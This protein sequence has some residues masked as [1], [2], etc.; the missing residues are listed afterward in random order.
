MEEDHQRQPLLEHLQELRKRIIWSVIVI[1]VGLIGSF[2]SVTP[3]FQYLVSVAPVENL[4]LNAL[5][6]FDAI[7]LYMKFALVISLV[8]AL[9]FMLFQIWAFLKPALTPLE[10]RETLRCVP[11]VLI[12]FL[13][14]V[15][16]AYY[17][18]FPMAFL[19]T[20]RVTTSMGLKETYGV[21]QYFTFLFNIV[22]PVSLLFELPLVI[23][24]L[25]KLGILNPSMLTKMRKVAWFAMIVI[26]TLVTP[27]DFI[28][29]ILV[30]VPLIVLYEF[31]VMLSRLT[32]RK[33]L[34]AYELRM[35]MQ[36]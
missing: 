29:D 15:A 6:P 18:V 4:E 14:G 1:A 34:A 24:F 27:P 9:P 7:G 33:N 12:M 20:E 13:L 3:L 21:I 30:S 11:G 5:S 22:M 31:S 16:F 8:L 35:T 25:T 10:Q 26:A 36:E 17:I 23:L 28:S 19:F 2:F 32:Y